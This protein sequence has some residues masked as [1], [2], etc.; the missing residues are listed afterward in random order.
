MTFNDDRYEESC[1]S[2][3]MIQVV[4]NGLDDKLEEVDRRSEVQSSVLHHFAV[5]GHPV[6]LKTVGFPNNRIA[7]IL[8]GGCTQIIFN[9]P[10]HFVDLS[11]QINGHVIL[12]DGSQVPVRG[13]GTVNIW[14]CDSTPHPYQLK[15]CLYVPDLKYS[16]VG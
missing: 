14:N 10:G 16:I 6:S 12:A 9:H 11:F 4:L 7:V 5:T 13:I 2:A 8:D 3:N 15:D 1:Y